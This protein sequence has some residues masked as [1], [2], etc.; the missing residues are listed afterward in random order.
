MKATWDA[1]RLQ[2][3]KP[4]GALCGRGGRADLSLL[5]RTPLLLLSA[6]RLCWRLLAAAAQVGQRPS[7]QRNADPL[8]LN[9]LARR[10]LLAGHIN[11][12]TFAGAAGLRDQYTEAV[13]HIPTA[14][15]K[16]G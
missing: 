7:E 12:H 4:P 2:R 10:Q 15:Y 6:G 13:R 14:P 9:T 5:L 11:G 16:V 1:S 3:L 8:T